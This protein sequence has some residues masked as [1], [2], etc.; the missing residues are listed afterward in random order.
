M[1]DTNQTHRPLS[2]HLFI[3]R[4]Q[5]NMVM[6]ISHRLTGLGLGLSGILV[7]WW[8]MALATSPDYFRV[9]DGVLT[10]WIGILVLLVSLMSL[11]YHFFSGIRHLVWDTGTG[12]DPELSHKTGYAVLIAAAVMTVVTVIVAI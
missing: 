10:S 6:S 3:Y 9:A 1:A 4:R 8:F 12:F 11:W 2:P 5:I 7:V